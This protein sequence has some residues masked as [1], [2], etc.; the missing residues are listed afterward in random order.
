MVILGGVQRPLFV[1]EFEDKHFAALTTRDFPSKKGDNEFVLKNPRFI[2]SGF[3]AAEN[4]NT[5]K[6]VKEHLKRL[7]RDY[8]KSN[9]NK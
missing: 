7:I 8:N 9:N 5:P 4:A 2:P 3:E 6:E 1:F